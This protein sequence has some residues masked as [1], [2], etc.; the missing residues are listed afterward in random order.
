MIDETAVAAAEAYAER[1]ER[2]VAR[3]R[4][5]HGFSESEA[6]AFIDQFGVPAVD[7]VGDSRETPLKEAA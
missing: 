2:L 4:R 7:S 3:L 5:L 1:V 6:V